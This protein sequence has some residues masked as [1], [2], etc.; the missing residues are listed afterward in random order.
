VSPHPAHGERTVRRR[1]IPMPTGLRVLLLTCVALAGVAAPARAGD[2]TSLQVMTFNVR[3]ADARPPNAWQDRRPLVREV[4]ERWAPDVI[5]TQEGIYPQLLDMERDLPGYA[6]IGI[7]RDGGSRGEFMAVFYRTDRLVPLEFGDFWLS[8][9]PETMGSRTWGTNFNRMVT[10]V[11]F[12]DVRSGREFY[13]V[14]THFDHEV[15]AARERSAQLVLD[16][17]AR[18]DASLPVL[19]IGDFNADA[20][21]NPVY[22]TLVTRG[23]FTDS[24]RAAGH[25]EPGFGTFHAFRGMEVAAGRHR[26]DWIL[27]RGA[28]RTRSSEIVTWSRDGRYPSDHYP[29]VA[30]VEFVAPE[31]R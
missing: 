11:R 25:E 23:G 8:D 22:D 28:V 31:A 24:W 18:F 29:V 1:A 19:L 3:F 20:G 30:R 10:W 5:G 9:T 2:D 17:M 4:I 16:R 21:R 15:Q 6:R 26:I 12:R 27:T 7:G 13:V 14:N